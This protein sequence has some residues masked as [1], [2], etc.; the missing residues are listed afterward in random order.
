MIKALSQVQDMDPEK[1]TE[2]VSVAII[3][4]VKQPHCLHV[5][6]TLIHRLRI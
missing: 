6:H 5:H 3:Q 2:Q 4:P 1:F